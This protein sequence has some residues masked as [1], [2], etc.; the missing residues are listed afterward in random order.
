MYEGH[1]PNGHAVQKHSTGELFPVIIV[2]YGDGTKRWIDPTKRRSSPRYT[3]GQQEI[4][5]IAYTY[6][7]CREV[8]PAG[9]A[10]RQEQDYQHYLGD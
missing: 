2:V 5:D 6:L 4:S 8:I 1:L 3:C 10:A 9:M 7:Q